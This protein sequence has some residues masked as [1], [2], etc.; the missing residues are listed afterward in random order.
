MSVWSYLKSGLITAAAATSI[1]ASPALAE[2]NF[3]FTTLATD[4]D[5]YPANYPY[6]YNFTFTKVL[7][8]NSSNSMPQPFQIDFSDLVVERQLTAFRS[9]VNEMYALQSLTS[10]II[11]TRDLPNPYTTTLSEFCGYYQV[12]GVRYPSNGTPTAAECNPPTVSAAPAP[13]IEVA[14]TYTPPAPRPVPALW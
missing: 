5:S 7:D 9:I 2:P 12:T 6:N 4:Q 1:V 11:R 3:S 14:P 13:V 8:I 10:P